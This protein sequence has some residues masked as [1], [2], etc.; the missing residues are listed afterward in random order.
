MSRN[1]KS[2]KN[3]RRIVTNR[4]ASI[5]TRIDRVGNLRTETVN[6][7]D[8]TVR[9]AVSTSKTDATNLY[10]DMPDG[11]GPSFRLDGRTARTVYR[12]LKKHYQ[13]T[14]KSH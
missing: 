1:S 11:S 10:I 6:R 8:G 2:T 7:D 4:N 14:N 5:E 9:I 12:A 13:N 3:T